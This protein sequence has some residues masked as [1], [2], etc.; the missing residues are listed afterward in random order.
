[1]ISVSENISLKDHTTICTGGKARYLIRCSSEEEVKETLVLAKSKD[2]PILIMGGGSN[3]LIADSGFPGIVLDL[4]ISGIQFGDHDIVTAGA[5]VSWDHFVSEVCLKGLSGVEALSGIPGRV[6]ASPV[7]NIGAYGQEVSETIKS[8]RA[9]H[10]DSLE[11]RDFSNPECHFSYRDSRFKS[12]DAGQWIILSVSFGLHSDN[13]P[14]VKYDELIKALNAESKWPPASRLAKIAMI[15]THVLRI[16]A[17]KGMVLDAQ[18]PDS[19]SLGS[20]FI[21]PIVTSAVI[22]QVKK[23]SFDRK[24]LPT[25]VVYPAGDNLWKLSAAWLIEKAGITKGQFLGNARVST[26]HVLALTNPSGNATTAEILA[27]AA[28]I[29]HQVHV[30]FGIMLVREPILV[31]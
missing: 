27:L 23:I 3:L 12:S 7:Q 25:P 22:D 9:L 4:A 19:R 1:M 26:K 15:R 6:G 31:P 2:L 30:T 10:R 18:D 13:M 29:Q 5:G 14:E 21:N 28:H 20:F 17:K 8:V 16:R 11:V 24:L